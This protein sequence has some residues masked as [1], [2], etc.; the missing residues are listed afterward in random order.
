M[1]EPMLTPDEV[2]GLLGCSKRTVRRLV[3][4]GHMPEPVRIGSLIRW[5]REVIA[6]WIAGG[7]PPQE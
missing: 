4:K 3:A 7:C 6:T 5:P 2:A 1:S